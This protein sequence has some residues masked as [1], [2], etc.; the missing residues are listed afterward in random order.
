MFMSGLKKTLVMLRQLLLTIQTLE[1]DII[2]LSNWLLNIP[3]FAKSAIRIKLFIFE[4]KLVSIIVSISL[5]FG[6]FFK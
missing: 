5:T 1:F 6:R 3:I 4:L 2:V